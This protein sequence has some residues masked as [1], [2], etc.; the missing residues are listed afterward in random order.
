MVVSESF[1]AGGTLGC[2]DPNGRIYIGG[3]DPNQDNVTLVHEVGHKADCNDVVPSATR[4][5]MN[6]TA[7]GSGNENRQALSRTLLLKGDG[8]MNSRSTNRNRVIL[9]ALAG[10]LCLIAIYVAYSRQDD[11]A[12]E[13]TID[14]ESVDKLGGPQARSDAESIV[15]SDLSSTGDAGSTGASSAHN[16]TVVESRELDSLTADV[17]REVDET[18]GRVLFDRRYSDPREFVKL[19]WFSGMSYKDA[20]RLIGK[21]KVPGLHQMLEDPNYAAYWHQ[22]AR[23]IGFVSEDQNSVPVLMRYFQ[24]DDSWNWRMKNS[25][26]HKRLAGKIDALEFMGKLGG[27]EAETFLREAVTEQGAARVA[28]LW[29]RDGLLPTSSTFKT[30]ENT[31][32]FVRGRAA[33]GLVFTGKPENVEIVRRYLE[34]EI[35]YCAA[36][37]TYTR[38]YNP[39]ASA[40][41]YNDFI[42]DNGLESLFS[43]F[44]TRER[45]GA[46][47]PYIK[48]YAWQNY[49]K[50]EN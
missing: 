42:A 15:P 47:R 28:G 30:Q 37:N 8:T 40:M 45:V 41:V 12:P 17:Y 1:V 20:R 4:R 29:L 10:V 21:E 43:L 22:V 9:I 11:R 2:T 35:A 19:N 6:G 3:E 44:G 36:N 14:I 32:V 46:L 25:L 39:L 26:G 31:V 13:Q 7:D 24:R 18:V 48:K 5:I 50:N 27:H 23:L 38:L 33:M 16:I 34:E 49:V